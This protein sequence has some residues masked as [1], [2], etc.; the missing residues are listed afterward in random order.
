MTSDLGDPCCVSGTLAAGVY[1]NWGS[2]EP[3]NPAQ[4]P[5][6][7]LYSLNG[8]WNTDDCSSLHAFFCQITVV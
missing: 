7:R 5:C 2:G 6:V 8:F 3:L 1:E 4:R